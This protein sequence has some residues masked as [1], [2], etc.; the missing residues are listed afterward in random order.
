M[1]SAALDPCPAGVRALV[2]CLQRPQPS[3]RMGNTIRSVLTAKQAMPFLHGEE[4]PGAWALLNA[5]SDDVSS[6]CRCSPLPPCTEPS[7]VMHQHPFT[8][9]C[10]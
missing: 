1:G 5:F 7:G 8:S 10:Y 6:T 9:D 2:R 3:G 4:A